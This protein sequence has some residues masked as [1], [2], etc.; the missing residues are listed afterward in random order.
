MTKQD[1]FRSQPIVLSEE[2][3]FA[4]DFHP[5]FHHF[6]IHAHIFWG[7]NLQGYSWLW[8]KACQYHIASTF[9]QHNGQIESSTAVATHQRPFRSV[10]EATR[11]VITNQSV[12]VFAACIGE[13]K[14]RQRWIRKRIGKP[15]KTIIL[16][17]SGHRGVAPHR[18]SL[19][20]R[21]NSDSITKGR[22][23]SVQR[24][25][26]STTTSKTTID[27]SV[28]IREISMPKVRRKHAVRSNHNTRNR[29]ML[30]AGRN[31]NPGL[32]STRAEAP[33]PNKY[34]TIPFSKSFRTLRYGTNL[35]L[36]PVR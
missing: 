4:D 26:T 8:N 34:S 6:Y 11:I 1:L 7:R 15:F 36:S 17:R 9:S 10:P 2:Y 28:P 25:T 24:R 12:G 13:K 31:D 20:V 19:H 5:S 21:C 32:F 35:C 29:K 14:F 23:S 27:S 18:S 33:L 30:S 3:D 22:G 16:K